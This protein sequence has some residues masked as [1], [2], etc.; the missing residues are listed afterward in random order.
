MIR[1]LRP[2]SGGGPAL[3]IAILAQSACSWHARSDAEMEARRVAC[4]QGAAQTCTEAGAIYDRGDG[5][6]RDR[7]AAAAFYGK[8]CAKGDPWGC[9]NRGMSLEHGLGVPRDVPA[10]VMAYEQAC[11]AGI[12]DGCFKVAAVYDDIGPAEARDLW[13]A[14]L[15]YERACVLNLPEACIRLGELYGVGGLGQAALSKAQG[16]FLKACERNEPVACL[17]LALM[18]EMDPRGPDAREKAAHWM[19]RGLQE[20]EQGCAG[21]EQVRCLMLVLVYSEGLVVKKD[22][23]RATSYVELSCSGSNA[24]ACEA[25]KIAETASN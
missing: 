8:G 23:V 9:I 16:R 17:N 11:E 5:V 13:Q 25:A 4:E 3:L 19:S 24:G 22:S 18:Q 21:G 1:V 10:A 7:S 20:F 2:C 6:P 12:G 14:A 15:Y